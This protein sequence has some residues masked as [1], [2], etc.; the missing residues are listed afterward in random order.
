MFTFENGGVPEVAKV[1]KLTVS[2]DTVTV[3]PSHAEIEEVFDYVKIDVTAD[4]HPANRTMKQVEVQSDSDGL[5]RF[6]ESA[7][8]VRFAAPLTS[9]G[10]ECCNNCNN[11][12]RSALLLPSP[13]SEIRHSRIRAWS[14]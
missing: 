1:G 4:F 3:E 5:L 14:A 11:L 13:T 9:V 2:G 6:C 10:T 8:E 7:E 12:K